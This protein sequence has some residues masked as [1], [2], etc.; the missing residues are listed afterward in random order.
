MHLV[1]RAAG[2]DASE[3]FR[4]ALDSH[5]ARTLGIYRAGEQELE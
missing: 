3:W 5:Q 1:A 4:E 2:Q